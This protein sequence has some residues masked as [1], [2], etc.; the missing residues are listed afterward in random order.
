[1]ADVNEGVGRKHQLAVC[2]MNWS[3]MLLMHHAK[4][5]TGWV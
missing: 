3:K 5:K 1:V 4:K 2:L